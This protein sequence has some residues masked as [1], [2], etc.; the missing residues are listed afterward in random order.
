TEHSLRQ[1]LA[2]ERHTLTEALRY[3][4][5]KTEWGLKMF[6]E[7]SALERAAKQGDAEL[8]RLDA[9]LAEASAGTAYLRRKQLDDHLAGA[10]A[11]LIDG[12]VEDVHGRLAAVAASARVNPPQR[13]EV[14]GHVEPMVLNG[15]YL[16]EDVALDDFHACVAE[17]AAQYEGLGCE[18]Q[19]TGPW[20]PYNFVETSTEAA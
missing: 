16:L 4:A 12:C 8:A 10:V 1:V 13:P 5:G 7:R 3:L 17:L 9:E 18:L 2:R 6:A 20:P 15:A 19:A 14:S 11:R